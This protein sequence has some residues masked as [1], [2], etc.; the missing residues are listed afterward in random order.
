[1]LLLFYIL[2]E[3]PEIEHRTQILSEKVDQNGCFSF[4]WS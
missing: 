3:N 2:V 4:K 1:M